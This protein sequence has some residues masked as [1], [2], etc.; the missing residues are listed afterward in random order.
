MGG[1]FSLPTSLPSISNPFKDMKLP[2]FSF[3]KSAS[4][5]G[6]GVLSGIL[7]PTRTTVNGPFGLTSRRTTTRYTPTPNSV[8]GIA[9]GITGLFFRDKLNKMGKTSQQ[10]I[11]NPTRSS[12]SYTNISPL[13]SV[14]KVGKSIDYSR[15]RSK[16]LSS[17]NQITEPVKKEN[18]TLT[19][20]IKLQQ[21]QEQEQQEQQQQQQQLPPQNQQLPPQTQ[22]QTKGGSKKKPSENKKKPSE[23]KKKPS[24]NKKKPS[25]NKKKPSE[26]KKKPSENKKKPSENKMK[27]SEK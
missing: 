22:L 18:L 1:G 24:E 7:G 27:P 4:N 13:Q 25:E 8:S 10:S 12:F 6:K 9:G 23:N 5:A 11:I 26:N 19:N 21:Q 2:D 3:P 16:S 15:P 14:V 17:I 20:K